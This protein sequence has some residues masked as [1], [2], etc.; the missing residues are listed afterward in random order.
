MLLL[1][2]LT[3]SEKTDVFVGVGGKSNGPSNLSEEAVD[4]TD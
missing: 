2:L 3:D 1:W 4:I